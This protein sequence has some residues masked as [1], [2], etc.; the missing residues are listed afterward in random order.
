MWLT[1]RRWV[2]QAQRCHL[3]QPQRCTPTHQCSGGAAQAGGGQS[4]LASVPGSRTQISQVAA[5]RCQSGRN[6]YED[7]AS[8]LAG[9]LEVAIGRLVDRRG[10]RLLMTGGS[11]L[12]GASLLG[13]ASIQQFWQ[14][15]LL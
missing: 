12:A 15:Y 6:R 2:E 7:T 8:L 13:L 5:E 11:L 14:F 4:L 10:A 3:T 1:Y 9:L